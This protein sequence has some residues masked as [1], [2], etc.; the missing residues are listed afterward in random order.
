[1]KVM[2]RETWPTVMDGAQRS[3]LILAP[4]IDDDLVK[5][6]LSFLPPISVKILFP[7]TMLESKG[8]KEFRYYL[9]EVLDINLDVDIRVIDEDIA[10]CLVV[11][12]EKFF[13]SKA[14]SEILKEQ[15]GEDTKTGI[16]YA[17]R[18]WEQGESWT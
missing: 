2:K 5:E 16:A 14:Y 9:R 4:W 1:M 17:N 18:A 3:L 13:Y 6:L 11:D 12:A 15:G 10:A 7:Q 8:H